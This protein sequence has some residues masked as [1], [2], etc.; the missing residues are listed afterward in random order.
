MRVVVTGGTGFVGAATVRVLAAAGL[1]V[2]AVDLRPPSPRRPLPSAVTVHR[3]DAG[4]PAFAALVRR[5]RPQAVI[6]LAAQTRV[7]ASLRDPLGDFEAN[8]AMTARVARWAAEAGAR[9]LVFASSAAVYGQPQAVPLPESAPCRPLSPYGLHKLLAEQYLLGAA[10]L[11]GLEVVVLRYAN[12]YGPGQEAGLE[13]GVVA[14]FV[15]RALAGLPL[16][17]EGDGLQTRDFVFVDDVARANLLALTAAAPGAVLNVGT[18]QQVSVRQL[19]EQVLAL[20][21]E[22]PLEAAPPRPGDIRHSALDPA[23]AARVLGWRAEVPLDEGLRRTVA[24][25]R[26]ALAAPQP[27]PA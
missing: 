21:G 8:V 19:A 7:A 25:A 24:A 1:E 9:R 5:L 4:S 2:H 20:I 18:G 16:R 12:V 27:S 10:H 26:A 13:G 14:S 6:H 11:Y 15:E 22:R 17:V 23:A 3:L